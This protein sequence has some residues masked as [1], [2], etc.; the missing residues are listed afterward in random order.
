MSRFPPLN[1]IRAFV[2]AA[3]HSSLKAAAEELCVTP[4]AISRQ[5][6]TLETYFGV[7]LFVRG[8]RCVRLTA[9][10]ARYFTRVAEPL[11]KL[12]ES[13]EELL[14]VGS[15]P[16]VRIDCVPTFAMH[17]LLPRL[18]QF[19]SSHPGAEVSV[20][21]SVGPV[22]RNREFDF[23]IRRD[24]AHFSG[25]KATRLMTE[26]CAPVCSP[27][28]K[29]LSRLRSIDDLVRFKAIYIRV[30]GD[31]WPT[32]TAAAGLDENKL[33][34]RLDVDQTFFAIQAAED[35]LGIAVVPLLFVRRQLESG[36]LVEPIRR[37]P[38]A[39]GAYFLLD[40]PRGPRARAREFADWLIDT[41]ARG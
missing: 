4:G 9:A 29:G 15:L 19:Q 6:Q 24:P 21:T 12:Q 34:N 25:L 2:A 26:Y 11:S 20:T 18:P 36:R 23:A 35:G 41:A 33:R 27:A 1:A 14:A 31:L 32:W 28:L 8:Y 13:S 10:G 5:V 37:K 38:A 39:S 40:P 22:D 17:W 30:R 3:K 16:V 7:P